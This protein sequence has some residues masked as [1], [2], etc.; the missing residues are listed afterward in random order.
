MKQKNLPPPDDN[1]RALI[2]ENIRP[3]NNFWYWRDKPIG[4]HGTASEVLQK[5]GLKVIGLGSRP[6]NQDPPDCEGMLDGQWSGVEVTELVHRETLARSIKSVRQRAAGC[7]PNEPEAYFVWDR[8]DFLA[9][10]QGLIDTK[11]AATLKGGPYERYV[12]VIHTDEFF[13]NSNA[14]GDAARNPQYWIVYLAS[15]GRATARK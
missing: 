3:W 4:E 11:D 10:V 2:E 12:L 15:R 14:V 6:E 8:N 13:L 7:E 1:L 9:A 5:A